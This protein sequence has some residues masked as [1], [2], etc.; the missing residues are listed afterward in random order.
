MGK[1]DITGEADDGTPGPLIVCDPSPAGDAVLD[2]A[3][4]IVLA[5]LGKKPSAVIKPLG[6]NLRQALHGRPT[7]PR[8]GRPLLPGQRPAVHHHRRR[9]I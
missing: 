6:K 4:A 5:H 1:V 7:V 3:L 2:A 9:G 8:D